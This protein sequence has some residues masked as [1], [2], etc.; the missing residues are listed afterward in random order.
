MGRIYRVGIE[1]EGGWRYPTRPD[2]RVHQDA[3][4]H[5]PI[6]IYKTLDL[7]DLH[8]EQAGIVGEIMSPPI[9]KSQIGKWLEDNYPPGWFSS[10]VCERRCSVGLHTHVSLK[11]DADYARLMAPAFYGFFMERANAFASTLPDTRYSRTLRARLAGENR[12]CY[13]RLDTARQLGLLDK[14]QSG[15][16]RDVRRTILNYAYGMHKTLECRVFPMAPT[17][18]EAKTAVFLFIHAVEDF[19]KDAPPLKMKRILVRLKNKDLKRRQDDPV[20]KKNLHRNIFS[21]EFDPVAEAARIREETTRI[22]TEVRMM[23]VAPPQPVALEEPVNPF[24][25]WLPP[26]RPTFVNVAGTLETTSLIAAT[27]PLP[28]RR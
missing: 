27:H 16:R 8:P 11:A 7:V 21:E 12:F 6:Y 24:R 15:E 20:K 3:S 19:L 14:P 18:G 22:R 13:A 26:Q 25:A 28:R 5:P 23:R 1:L 10:C 2:Q 17:W 9:K 4:V